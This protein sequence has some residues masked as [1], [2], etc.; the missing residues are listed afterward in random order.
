MIKELL[1]QIKEHLLWIINHP[2]N[3]IRALKSFCCYLWKGYSYQD[4]WAVDEYL[5]KKFNNIIGDFIKDAEE[6]GYP[7]DLTHE[8]WI[9][10]L[11]K[12]KEWS[13]LIIADEYSNIQEAL[14]LEKIQHQWLGFMYLHFFDLWT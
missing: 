8:E 12:S 13:D 5:M 3:T 11:K 14:E 10:L 6:I 1:Y 7:A 2:S 9:A 4:L